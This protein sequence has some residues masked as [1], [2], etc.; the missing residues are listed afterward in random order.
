MGL[1]ECGVNSEIIILP[2]HLPY[3]KKLLIFLTV[4]HMPL[5]VST[6]GTQVAGGLEGVVF[7]GRFQDC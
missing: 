3:N 1:Q 2:Y 4:E 6:A 7:S 5:K